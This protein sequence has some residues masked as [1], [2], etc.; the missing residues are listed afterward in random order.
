MRG[1]GGVDVSIVKSREGLDGFNEEGSGKENSLEEN[2]E[3]FVG[4]N[5]VVLCCPTRIG[6]RVRQ[7]HASAFVYVIVRWD[8]LILFREVEWS[9]R[10]STL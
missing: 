2:K 6:T 5:M 4:L 10:V 7:G 1:I 3:D 8:D 9:Q